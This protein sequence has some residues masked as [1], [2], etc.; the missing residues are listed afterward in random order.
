MTTLRQLNDRWSLNKHGIMK[1][2]SFPL[3]GESSIP[4]IMELTSQ[5]LRCNMVER[6]VRG[7]AR[8][9]ADRLNHIQWQAYMTRRIKKQVPITSYGGKTR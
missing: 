4:T 5:I 1:S 3:P 2:D 8:R 6:K 7:R 9:V